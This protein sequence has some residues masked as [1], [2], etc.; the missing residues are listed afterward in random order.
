M[1]VVRYIHATPLGTQDGSSCDN[2]APLSQLDA[3]MVLAGAGGNVWLRAGDEFY[4]SGHSDSPYVRMQTETGCV[5]VSGRHEDGRYGYAIIKGDRTAYPYKSV[6]STAVN[7]K[8]SP[9]GMGA[10][11]AHGGRQM[12][13]NVTLG[14]MYK[15]QRDHELVRWLI[16]RRGRARVVASR[17][18]LDAD[19][20]AFGRP[21]VYTGVLKALSPQDVD[22][23][24]SDPDPFEVV[25]TDGTIG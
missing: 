8:Y 3:Q 13:G 24:S 11:E 17:Q 6:R 7:T 22:S 5:E 25:S 10:E 2:A 15:R 20:N 14:R 12:V 1:A 19:G 23:N 4:L 16:T 21:L 18:P 9:G